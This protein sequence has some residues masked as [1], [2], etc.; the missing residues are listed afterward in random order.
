MVSID[1]AH[2]GDKGRALMNTVTGLR[3]TYNVG[4]FLN[5]F[6]IWRLLNKGLAHNSHL[7]QELK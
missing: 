3:V 5:S 6:T 1:V 4:K 2:D 7:L